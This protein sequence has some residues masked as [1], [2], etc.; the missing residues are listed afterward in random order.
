MPANAG[1]Q[2]RLEFNLWVEKN[3]LKEGTATHS[4]IPAWRILLRVEPGFQHIVSN[5]SINLGNN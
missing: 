2:K 1:R 3:P 5:C 4:N